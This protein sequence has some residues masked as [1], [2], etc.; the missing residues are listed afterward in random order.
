[1]PEPGQLL[2]MNV[3]RSRL[4]EYALA[5]SG[6][7]AG[8]RPT[9]PN[10]LSLLRP[11]ARSFRRF[12]SFLWH[13][14]QGDSPLLE[15]ERATSELEDALLESLFLAADSEQSGPTVH[16]PD[17]PL[18]RAVDYIMA[19][20]DR[21]LSVGRIAAASGVHGRTLQ[22]AFRARFGASVTEY[23]R[24]C[25]LDRAHAV[26]LAS[27]PAVTTVTDVAVA[28]GFSHLGRFSAAYM[29]RF[30]ELPSE[31]LRR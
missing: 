3:F 13:E 18:G 17:A 2:V 20:L 9:L 16:L 26:L 6:G 14:A 5:R 15:S 29:R 28:N 24:G 25:R 23:V 1:M 8:E 21:P 19:N 10:R 12:L 30:S 22:R 11:A 31:T 7:E 4:D 27:D